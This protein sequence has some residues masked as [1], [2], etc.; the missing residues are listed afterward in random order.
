MKTYSQKLVS[1]LMILTMLLSVFPIQAF[2][3]TV[4][5]TEVVDYAMQ[6]LGYPYVSAGKGPDNFDCSGFVH[7]IFKHFGISFPAGT[8]SYNT[9][10][11]AMAYGTVFYDMSQAE[12]GDLV[13]WSKHIAIYTEN[14]KCINALNN[15]N[16]VCIIDVEAYKNGVL[17]PPHFFLRP[18]FYE[19]TQENEY[20]NVTFDEYNATLTY[21]NGVFTATMVDPDLKENYTINLNEVELHHPEHYWMI[22]FTDGNNNFEVGTGHWKMDSDAEEQYASL[23][24]MNSFWA[25]EYDEGSF[26]QLGNGEV[27]LK[28][29]GT[30]LIWTF[31]LLGD[32]IYNPYFD[33]FDAE[34]IEISSIRLYH[35]Y[36]KYSPETPN[37]EPEPTFWD[38]IINVFETIWNYIKMPFELL[39]GLFA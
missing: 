17:N 26:V 3:A 8:A 24:E 35:Y 36:G 37:T 34:N 39:I 32:G 2:G 14:G 38:A 18:S 19:N 31:R 20:Y 28:I 33:E 21:D 9:E 15:D 6:F 16:G 27:D 4:S 10:D 11:K 5:G 30:K 13:I 1:M 23:Y 25:V 22:G 7:Y 29:E 12:A